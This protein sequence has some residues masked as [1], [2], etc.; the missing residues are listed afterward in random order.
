MGWASVGRRGYDTRL[1]RSLVGKAAIGEAR[2]L[3]KSLGA[4]FCHLFVAE[5]AELFA[6]IGS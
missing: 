6:E 3:I 4:D 1:Q 5:A 2:V